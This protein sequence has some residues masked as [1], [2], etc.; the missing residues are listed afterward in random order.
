MADFLQGGFAIAQTFNGQKRNQQGWAVAG[1]TGVDHWA[2]YKLKAPIQNE[3]GTILTFKM[4]QFHNAAEHTLGRFRISATTATGD[5]PLGQPESFA[6]VLATKK[7]HRSDEDNA[8][9]AAYVGATDA[10]IRKANEGLANANKPVPPDSKLVS[11]EERKKLL[12]NPTPD[13][14]QLVQLRVDVEQSTKQLQNIQLTAVEDLTWA[15]INSP[16]F[17]F[18]H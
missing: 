10:E 14:P 4:H 13:D 1:A 3:G 18:N 17:L 15:L 2:T 8:L 12:S 11:L 6:A 16:A 7:E 5:I 9:L